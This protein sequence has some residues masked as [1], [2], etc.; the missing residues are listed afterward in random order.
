MSW[1]RVT[2]HR[3]MCHMSSCHV[4]HVTCHI[5]QFFFF[6]TKRWSLSVEGLL[7]TGPTPSSFCMTLVPNQKKINYLVSDQQSRVGQRERIQSV[8]PRRTR[9][10]GP[11]DQVRGH[12]QLLPAPCAHTS[13]PPLGPRR[14]QPQQHGNKLLRQVGHHHHHHHLYNQP[15][16]ASKTGE[17]LDKIPLF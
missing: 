10:R 14:R 1:S 12:L 6:L 3:V 8:V 13:R 15:S 5:S 11:V 9:C 17:A 2:C 7:S 4:S 16:S